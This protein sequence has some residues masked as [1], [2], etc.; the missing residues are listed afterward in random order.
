MTVVLLA[1]GT[2]L[3]SLG[4]F[5]RPEPLA[6]LFIALALMFPK[7]LNVE[8]GEEI[9]AVRIV[10]AAAAAAVCLS[11]LRHLPRGGMPFG[12]AARFLLGLG[13]LLIGVSALNAI[14]DLGTMVGDGHPREPM[15][16]P[17]A[18]LPDN[19]VSDVDVSVPFQKEV[20]ALALPA[21]GLV[22]LYLGLQ[23]FRSL[24]KLER[25]F[26]VLI[27]CALVGSVEGLL[28]PE[29]GI[30]ADREDPGNFDVLQAGLTFGGRDMIGRTLLLAIVG[31]LYFLDQR[32]V[33][34][35]YLLPLLLLF[36]SAILA[37]FS[38]PTCIAVVVASASYLV[39]RRRPGG[40]AKTPREL[41]R[42]GV[43]A[44]ARWQVAAGLA[45]A[46]LMVAFAFAFGGPGVL[47]RTF[48]DDVFGLGY[49]LGLWSFLLDWTAWSFPFGLGP[50]AVPFY[51]AESSIA[52][53]SSGHNMPF[54]FAAEFGLVGIVAMVACAWFAVRNLIRWRRVVARGEQAVNATRMGAAVYASL[55]GLFLV[56]QV[57]STVRLYSLYLLL[58][59]ATAALPELGVTQDPEKE[60]PELLQPA[61]AVADRA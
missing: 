21:Y 10:E 3:A 5:L 48:S 58:L 40:T 31:T 11:L 32:R 14:F 9:Q 59:A 55:I 30:A 6:Y 57:D 27:G 16:L 35:R 39:L 12:G 61:P 42:G 17:G 50:G 41:L 20:F 7:F 56:I 43:R 26:Q 29:L 37:T 28:L 51:F 25:L 22:F 8:I 33:R 38:A 23:F 49:R 46:A 60:D 47:D 44:V 4:F 54:E 52:R 24:G 34:P 15:H 45:A 53:F 19:A 2:G 13:V 36:G 18:D 1:F